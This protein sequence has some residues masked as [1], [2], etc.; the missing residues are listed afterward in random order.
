LD[1][2]RLLNQILAKQL[3]SSVSDGGR[4]VVDPVLKRAANVGLYEENVET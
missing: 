1:E 2:S 3:D 4:V